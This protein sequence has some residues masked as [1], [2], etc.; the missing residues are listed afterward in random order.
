MIREKEEWV[1][2]EKF[3]FNVFG[4]DSVYD[5]K[6]FSGKSNRKIK[7][8]VLDTNKQSKKLYKNLNIGNNTYNMEDI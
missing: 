7:E 6:S 8:Y 5:R 2:V 4:E 3:E 1:I